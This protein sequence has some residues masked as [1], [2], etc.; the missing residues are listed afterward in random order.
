MKLLIC[1]LIFLFSSKFSFSVTKNNISS[2]DKFG[3]ILIGPPASGKGYV[4]KKVIEKYNAGHI[5]VGELLR[6]SD[7]LSVEDKQ[8][9]SNG[10]LISGMDKKI[11]DMVEKKSKSYLF[12]GKKGIV[13]DGYPRSSSQIKTANIAIL[14]SGVKLKRV[15]VINCPDEILFERMSK[16][17]KEES[18]SDDKPEVLKERIS[19]YKK[20]SADI[21]N[22]YKK[23]G[24]VKEFDCKST[25]M[26]KDII[27]DLD[28]ILK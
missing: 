25:D 11:A 2:E 6:N 4:S 12:D 1:L 19:L 16:R 27:Q 26:S 18:R 7:S 28:V 17:A 10:Q 21:I 24:I 15:L 5:S 23:L 22:H 8:K 3:L 9:M 14:N 20:T 13:F